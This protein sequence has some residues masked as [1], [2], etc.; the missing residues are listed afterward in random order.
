MNNNRPILSTP[1]QLLAIVLGFFLV[2]SGF[3][4]LKKPLI[5]FFFGKSEQGYIIS[6]NRQHDFTQES[7]GYMYVIRITNGHEY[8]VQSDRKYDINES[9]NLKIAKS[10]NYAMIQAGALFNRE[11]RVMT[12]TTILGIIL[13]V[14]PF[15]KIDPNSALFR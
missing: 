4:I 8:N 14:L 11:I 12:G 1:F 2:L 7:R 6:A 10:G 9:V 3:L 15:I 5:T 13:I